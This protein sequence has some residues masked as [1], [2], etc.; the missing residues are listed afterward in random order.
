MG[1][2]SPAC[3]LPRC[4]CSTTCTS[5]WRQS[6]RW[7]WG[8]P[9]VLRNVIVFHASAPPLSQIISP[10]ERQELSSSLSS[11][12]EVA[13][14]KKAAPIVRLDVDLHKLYFPISGQALFQHPD[15][16]ETLPL[17]F[18]EHK[19]EVRSFPKC[20]HAC[21]KVICAITRTAAKESTVERGCGLTAFRAFVS[22]QLKPDLSIQYLPVLLWR[23]GCYGVKH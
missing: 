2:S 6:R 8:Q 12:P 1:Q 4:R 13:E 22:R 3:P 15:Q 19:D 5:G 10:H 16:M 7:C 11:E 14:V 20:I 21:S 9:V 23:W 18:H 17:E